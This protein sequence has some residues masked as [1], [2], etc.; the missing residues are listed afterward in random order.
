VFN[1]FTGDAVYLGTFYWRITRKILLSA[2]WEAQ[3]AG[4]EVGASSR[5]IRGI[6]LASAQIVAEFE[7]RSSEEFAKNDRNVCYLAGS[8]RSAAQAQAPAAMWCEEP[9]QAEDA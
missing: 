4:R 6:F 7:F 1:S 9:E 3:I 5:L 2:A 8:I